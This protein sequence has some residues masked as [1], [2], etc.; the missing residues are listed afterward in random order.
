[1]YKNVCTLKNIN[2]FLSKLVKDV[3]S[4]DSLLSWFIK[5]DFV[6]AQVLAIVRHLVTI[7]GTAAVAH[8]LADQSMVEGALGL[9]TT[10]VSFYLANLDVKGVDKKMTVALNTPVIN[11]T[12]EPAQPTTSDAPQTQYP[13]AHHK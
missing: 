9:A 13:F 2:I 3:S 6:R 10:A 4:M 5:S 1:V 11:P 7:A 8:G 12:P